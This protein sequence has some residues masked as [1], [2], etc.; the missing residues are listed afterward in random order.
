[1]QEVE[2]AEGHG[3]LDLRLRLLPGLAHRAVARALARLE[4]AR[5]RRPQAARRLDQEPRLE[6]E[7]RAIVENVIGKSYLALRMF[8]ESEAHLSNAHEIAQ[9]EGG[10]RA[11]LTLDVQAGRAQLLFVK[12]DHDGSEE[13]SRRLEP[14]AM[15]HAG[16][17]SPILYPG[18][19]SDWSTAGYE[20]ATG[21]EPGDAPA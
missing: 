11:P 9:A 13:L 10:A 7:A 5:R 12:G 6:G 2:L 14:L 17:G 4:V 20:V 19:W 16:V 15:E 3:D 18:S 8:P 21:S 1:M